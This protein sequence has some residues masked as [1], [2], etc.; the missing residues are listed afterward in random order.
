MRGFFAVIFGLLLLVS[1]SLLVFSNSTNHTVFNPNYLKNLAEKTDL[2]QQL[3]SIAVEVL[4]SGGEEMDANDEFIAVVEENITAERVETHYKSMV[5]QAFDTSKNEVVEDISWLN[6]KLFEAFE[7]EQLG[8]LEDTSEIEEIF[9][10]EIKFGKQD[11]NNVLISNQLLFY[12]S[13]VCSLIF[14]ISLFFVSSLENRSRLLWAGWFS[15]VAAFGLLLS[16]LF[17]F[18]ANPNWAFGSI[19]GQEQISESTINFLLRV[20]DQIRYDLFLN[21]AYS[22]AI[23]LIIT[24]A[25][26]IIASRL[27]P[28]SVKKEEEKK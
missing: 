10:G 8:E 23:L 1:L 26:F 12:L 24:V 13:I 16:S 2:Y 19:Y 22:F 14:I 27:A 5:D 20:V 15:A 4:S 17:L 9:P 7:L 6:E 25:L 18:L 21:H 28:K 3:P 11:L